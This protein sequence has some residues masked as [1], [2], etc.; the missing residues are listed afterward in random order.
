MVGSVLF[1]DQRAVSGH[2]CIDSAPYHG[3]WPEGVAAV[4]AGYV[5]RNP[6]S[7]RRRSRSANNA[8]SSQHK[9]SQSDVQ[10]LAREFTAQG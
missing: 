10:I 2:E 4:A 7:Y 8:F 1:L 3:R 6:N 9:A 5:D